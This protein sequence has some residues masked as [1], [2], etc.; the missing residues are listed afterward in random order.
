MEQPAGRVIDKDE[1][2]A[3]WAAVLE[4]Q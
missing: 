1:Q 3:F 2:G 4:P